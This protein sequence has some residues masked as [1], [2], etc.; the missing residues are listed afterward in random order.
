MLLKRSEKI[1]KDYDVIVIGGGLAGMTTANVLARNNHKVLLLEA[2]NKLG[3]FATWF[4]RRG[5]HIFDVS[6]HGFPH[7]MIKT[8]RKYWN[9]D[10]AQDIVQLKRIRFINPEFNLETTFTRED[11]TDKLLN[12]FKIDPNQVKAF[13][14]YIFNANFYDDENMTNAQLFEKFFPNRKDVIR[15]LMEPIVYANGSTLEDP[16]ISYCI[17]FSNFMKKGVYT[18]IGGTDGVIK[19][20]MN[21]LIDNGVDIKLLT[22]IEKISINNKKVEG[23]YINGKL[24]KAKAVLSNSNLQTTIFNMVGEKNFSSSY[25]KDAIKTRMNSSSCQ[26]Y[27]GIKQG[28]VVENIGDLIFTSNDSTFSTDALLSKD[29]SCRTFSIY[30]PHGRPGSNQYTIVSSTNAKWKDWAELN[31]KDYEDQKTKMIVETLDAL[32]KLIPGIKN[33]IDYVE[34]ATPKTIKR[35]THHEMGSSFGTKF[36][37]LSVSM[38]MHKEIDGLFHAGS[39]GIIMS[40]WLGAANYGAIQ[41]NEIDSY[42][43]N[44]KNDCQK[45]NYSQTINDNQEIKY[46]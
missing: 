30:Y 6:L 21:Q 27:M 16:A 43:Y 8:C 37:G 7:G 14:E 22:K 46:V 42:I 35:Y 45:N 34:A 31:E 25:I 18:F 32:E 36:E 33:K 24:I 28:E 2:H 23:V 17:V 15:F 40:G 4:R 3:G 20:M 19:K 13:F 12:F 29:I 26:V 41:S 11:F 1:T 9:K 39:V 38:N 44:L 5:G 10:I